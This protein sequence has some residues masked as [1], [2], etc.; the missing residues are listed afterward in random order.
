[1]PIPESQQD[2]PSASSPAAAP[3]LSPRLE[4]WLSRLTAALYAVLCLDLLLWY[5]DVLPGHFPLL[6]LILTFVMGLF[7]LADVFWLRRRLM[8]AAPTADSSDLN[9]AREQYAPPWWLDWTSGLFPVV[10]VV[11]LLRSFLVEPFVIPSSSM[12]PTLQQGDFI[13]VDK[14][15]Y[16]LRAPVFHFRLT[17]GA[18]VAHGDVIVFSHPT[19]GVEYIK[20]VI[21]VPGDTVRY[22]DKTLSINGQNI[23]RAALGEYRDESEGLRLNQF[24]ESLPSHTHRILL[25]SGVSTFVPPPVGNPFRDHCQYD[26]TEQGQQTIT[27]KVPPGHFFVMGDNRDNSEDSRFWG[28]VPEENIAGRAF[29]IWMNFSNLRRLGRFE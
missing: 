7:W 26:Q 2:N 16:G 23:G 9:Q 12:L 6:L 4:L 1:M 25:Q 29:L 21:G 24:Q 3:T 14:F 17:A 19:R 28:F 20:R 22:E 27:C 8:A 10:A 15:H 18:A 13:L 11:F 5:L